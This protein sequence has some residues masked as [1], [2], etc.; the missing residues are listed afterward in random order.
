MSTAVLGRNARLIKG[1]TPIGWCK[2]ISVKAAADQSLFE[3]ISL[4]NFSLEIN[5]SLSYVVLEKKEE[6]TG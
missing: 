5:R 1:N 2:N 4:R 3:K 6:K